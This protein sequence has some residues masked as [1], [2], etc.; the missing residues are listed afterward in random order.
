M[1]HWS[2]N[3]VIKYTY[4]DHESMQHSDSDRNLQTNK[5]HCFITLCTKLFNKNNWINLCMYLCIYLWMCIILYVFIN[6]YDVYIFVNVYI[7]MCVYVLPWGTS[8]VNPIYYI[9]H[10]EWNFETLYSQSLTGC[11][12]IINPYLPIVPPCEI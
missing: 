1:F 9:I 5:C 2:L 8:V 11:T 6:M 10:L 4:T 7:Y 3:I 12:V